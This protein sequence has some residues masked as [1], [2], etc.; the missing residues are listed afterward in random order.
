M[1]E[2]ALSKGAVISFH[3]RLVPVN[4]CAPTANVFFVCFSISFVAGPMNSRPGST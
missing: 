1:P 3:D 4:L 2:Q